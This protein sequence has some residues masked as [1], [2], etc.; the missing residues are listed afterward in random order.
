MEPAEAALK[1]TYVIHTTVTEVKE[2]IKGTSD[3][4]HFEGSR[5]S[6]ALPK[7]SFIIGDEVEIT[8]KKR[9]KSN[10]ILG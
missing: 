5:E 4:V 6:I 9:D 3:W 1:F 10:A 8:I 2:Y 7:D